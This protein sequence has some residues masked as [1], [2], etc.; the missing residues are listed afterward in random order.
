MNSVGRL[1]LRG[2]ALLILLCTVGTASTRGTPSTCHARGGMPSGLEPF[3]DAQGFDPANRRVA[4]ADLDGDGRSEALVYLR[5]GDWCGSGGCTLLVLRRQRGD[6]LKVSQIPATRLP[7][8]LL[9]RRHHGWRSL[10]VHVAGGGGAAHD[11]VLDF[12]GRHYRG[13]PMPRA[14]TPAA[15]P[16]GR[17]LIDGAPDGMPPCERRVT[18]DQR[19][20]SSSRR[21]DQAINPIAG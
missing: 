5:G 7:I 16:A 17:T 6:W 18:G 15:N 1:R 20:R 12:D 2:V 21:T 13:N 4:L 14:A 11:A 3:L 8:R 9:E 10:Q 19:P